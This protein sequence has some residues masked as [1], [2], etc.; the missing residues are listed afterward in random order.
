MSPHDPTNAPEGLRDSAITCIRL[1]VGRLEERRPAEA[2]ALMDMAARRDLD[3]VLFAA[4]HGPAEIRPMAAATFALH[5]PR[6]GEIGRPCAIFGAAG[7]TLDPGK[8]ALIRTVFDHAQAAFESGAT[9]PPL[10]SG[11]YGDA[12]AEPDLPPLRVLFVMA[13]HVAANPLCI[14]SDLLFHFMRSAARAGLEARAFAADALIYDSPTKHPFTDGEIAEARCALDETLAAFRPDLLVFEGNFLPTPRTL[15]PAWLSD[16]RRR[17]GCRVVT[18]I[19]D[20][21]DL[22]QNCFAVWADASDA[23]LVFNAEAAKP[24]LTGQD[25]K[26]VLACGLPFDEALFAADGS[27]K[28]EAMT[29]V[30]TNA[31][32]RGDLVVLLTAYG[33]PISARLHNRRAG[34]APDMDEYAA[35]MRAAK[36]TCNTGRVENSRTLSLVTGR[37]FEAILAKTVLLEEIGSRLDDYFVPFV[38]YVPYASAH[39]LVMFSQFLLAHD[40]VR[41]RIAEQAHAWHRAHYTSG[42]FWRALLARLGLTRATVPDPVPA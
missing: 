32:N 31:R 18:V 35:L 4:L 22:A 19:P 40:D 15:D 27:G 13:R 28:T 9:P 3:V 34:E 36:L 24:Y 11:L 41:A 16:A 37:C 8:A 12:A 17:H 7:L 39:Q 25:D 29:L 14:E 42:R 33:V 10:L 30:G 21:Y 20:C 26:V 5:R 1:A 2:H 6:G 38:H 23:V